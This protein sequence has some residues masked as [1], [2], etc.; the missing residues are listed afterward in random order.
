MN[1]IASTERREASHA[2]EY[3][4]GE[5]ER[6]QK[7]LE[8]APNNERFVTALV[9]AADQYVVARGLEKTIIAGYHWFS[10]WGRDTMIA[11]PGLTLVT[12]RFDVAAHSAGIRS[13]R[14]GGM[15]PNRFPDAGE[16]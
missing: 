11:L 15:L 7:V 5:I 4:V 1:I 9:A 8:R 6:R 10:D 2:G 12:G 16:T 3:A 14:D 13:P